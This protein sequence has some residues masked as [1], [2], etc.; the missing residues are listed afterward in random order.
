M[1]N[2]WELGAEQSSH[3][4]QERQVATE[5]SYFFNPTST[6]AQLGKRHGKSL[7]GKT[8]QETR[9]GYLDLYFSFVPFVPDLPDLFG[10][11]PVSLPEGT[12][13][14]WELS[15]PCGST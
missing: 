2:Y 7:G 12:L 14:L 10:L 5:P 3:Y 9:N 13:D 1:Q 6:Q 4:T 8:C 11:F 15:G